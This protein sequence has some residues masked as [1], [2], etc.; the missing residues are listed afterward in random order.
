MRQF[1]LE[2][3]KDMK[4]PGMKPEPNIRTEGGVLY[5]RGECYAVSYGDMPPR[6]QR[7]VGDE[8][9]LDEAVRGMRTDGDVKRVVREEKITV[10]GFPAREVEFLATDGGT[11]TARVIV[12]DTRLYIVIGGGRFVR[13]GNANVRRFLDSFKV[14]DL[15]MKKPGR[16]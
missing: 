13:P 7:A 15:K 8:A 2:P 10:S 1:S 11:Y 4:V 9:L 6:N 12:A 14:T 16:D 3:D 5:K